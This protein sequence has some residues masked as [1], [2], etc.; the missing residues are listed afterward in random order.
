MNF[1]PGY[2]ERK[3]AVGLGISG[4]S[5]NDGMDWLLAD[6]NDSSCI[7]QKIYKLDVI[8]S[9]YGIRV[10]RTSGSALYNPQAPC[11][12]PALGRN[13]AGHRFPS[14]SIG[15]ICRDMDYFTGFVK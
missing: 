4:I 9:I 3:D 1:I 14:W 12:V 10:K 7:K 2:N 11:I 6:W 15:K 8:Q 13:R 5:G